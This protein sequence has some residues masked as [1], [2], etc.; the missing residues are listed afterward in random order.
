MRRLLAERRLRLESQPDPEARV[1]DQAGAVRVVAE[2][3]EA[4]ATKAEVTEEADAF[5]PAGFLQSLHK[6]RLQ[7]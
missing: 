5:G 2:E 4:E 3:A 7:R 1:A 6:C